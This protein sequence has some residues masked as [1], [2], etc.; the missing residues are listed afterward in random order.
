MRGLD[1]VERDTLPVGLNKLEGLGGYGGGD[2]RMIYAD[3]PLTREDHRQETRAS[4]EI[5]PG[6][7]YKG[8]TGKPRYVLEVQHYDAWWKDR[9]LSWRHQRTPP[10]PEVQYRRG[11][12][13]YTCK[14][15]TFCAW[16]VS[17]ASTPH[18]VAH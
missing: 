9:P 1:R 3:P 18:E 13:T 5:R 7:A 12:K 6:Q 11:T 17:L 2:V 10:P 14:L 15:E 8:R 16:A 4:V